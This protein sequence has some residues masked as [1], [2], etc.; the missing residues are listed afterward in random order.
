MSMAVPLRVLILEDEPADAEL[1]V[2]ALRQAGF[3]PDWTRVD[4]EE[5]YVRCLELSPDVILADHHLPQFDS[6]RALA[7]LRER[8]L[9]VPFVIVSGAIGQDLAVGLMEQGAADFVLKD[10][11]ARLGPAVLRALERKRLRDEKRLAEQR[12]LASERRFRALIEHSSDGIVLLRPEATISYASPSTARILGYVPEELAGRN[13]FDFV[14]PQDIAYV[15][16]QLEDLKQSPGSVVSAMFRMAH[17]DGSWRWVEM[18]GTNLLAEPDVQAI[19]I[20]LRDVTE[21]ERALCELQEQTQLLQNILESM[22]EGVIVADRNERFR[23]FNAAAQRMYG[24][25][26]AEAP[27]SEWPQIYHLHLPDGVTPFPADRLPLVRAIRG[28]STAETEIL[29]RRSQAADSLVILVSG[30][31]IRGGTGDVVG[32]VIVCHDVTARRQA[33]KALAERAEELARSN[34]ELQQLAYVAAHDLQEPLRMVASYVELLAERYKGRLDAK[35][36]K[37]INYAVEGADRMK[38]LVDALRGFLVLTTQ[39]GPFEPVDAAASILGALANLHQLIEEKGAVVTH[40]PLPSIKGDPAQ[41]VQLFQNLVGNA[42]KFCDGT[43]RVHVAAEW[44]G[45]EWV[46]SVRDNGIGIAPEHQERIFQIFQRLHG[47]DKYPGTGMGL[48]ICKKVV[49]RHGGRI[50]V[51]SRPGQGSTFLFTLPVVGRQLS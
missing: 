15:R 31:P 35:A 16:T 30:R 3:E 13:T 38:A 34:R 2:H 26:A 51:E 46:F 19:V 18:T 11:L 5:D 42:L 22:S 12:L 4:T 10:R 21:R 45:E 28:E 29:V 7:R 43:P 37:Y 47:R 17:K 25:G 48:A 1:A 40:D 20:N 49:E 39:A 32:G 36:D 27:S 14:H 6:V 24:R 44:T 8:G 50:W 33:H 9:D 23:I 41:M